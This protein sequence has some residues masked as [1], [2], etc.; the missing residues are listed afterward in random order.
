[1]WQQR[2]RQRQNCWNLMKQ[3]NIIQRQRQNCWN[4]MKEVNIMIVSGSYSIFCKHVV[5]WKLEI[6]PL[7]HVILIL[8]NIFLVC[9]LQETLTSSPEL[10]LV[11]SGRSQRLG[12]GSKATKW[13]FQ[14]QLVVSGEEKRFFWNIDWKIVAV[15]YHLMNKFWWS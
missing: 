12:S 9:S 2:Q 8:S 10:S 4:L 3:V 6:F 13:I 15:N 11:L 5:V 7:Y 14:L 1:M